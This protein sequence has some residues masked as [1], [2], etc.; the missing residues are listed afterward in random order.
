VKKDYLTDSCTYTHT[1]QIK[2]LGKEA[3]NWILNEP[4]VPG[5]TGS[6]QIPVPIAALFYFS[7]GW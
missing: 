7:V 5:N 2:D 1:G 3:V 4:S 6:F